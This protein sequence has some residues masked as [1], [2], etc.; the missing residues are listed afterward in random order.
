MSESNLTS[1]ALVIILMFITYMILGS[2]FEKKHIKIGH[3]ASITVVIGA[4]ISFS[5][6]WMGYYEFT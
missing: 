2:L 4:C 1:E 3:E 5:F 6:Y